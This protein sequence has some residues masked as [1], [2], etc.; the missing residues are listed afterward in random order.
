MLHVWWTLFFCEFL[1]LLKQSSHDAVKKHLTNTVV[2]DVVLSFLSN[3]WNS[4]NS[5][6]DVWRKRPWT[7]NWSVEW[8][9]QPSDICV[10]NGSQKERQALK[11]TFKEAKQWN[12]NITWRTGACK[13]FPYVNILKK[14]LSKTV[15]SCAILTSCATEQLSL[16]WPGL[17]LHWCVLV[18]M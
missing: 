12:H 13:D 10:A 5:H 11:P 8:T 2:N 6:Q 9:G 3:M 15:A 7:G 18:L 16:E 1:E 14:R 17:R 4:V